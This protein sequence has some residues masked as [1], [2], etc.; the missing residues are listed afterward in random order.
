MATLSKS[1]TLTWFDIGRTLINGRI[2]TVGA[3]ISGIER[4]RGIHGRS[5][6]EMFRELSRLNDRALRDIGVDRA[7]L[8]RDPIL[9]IKLSSLG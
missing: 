8:P 7:D 1:D 6:R 3:R 5:R 2:E 9:L 4:K